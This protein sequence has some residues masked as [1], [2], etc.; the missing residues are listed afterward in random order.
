MIWR[1]F[2]LLIGAYQRSRLRYRRRCLFR[3][4]CSEYV[5]RRLHERGCLAALG[6]ALE[7]A[8]QCRPG[9]T[10]HGDPYTGALAVGLPDGSSIGEAEMAE[11]LVRAMRPAA[12]GAETPGH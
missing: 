9:F 11:F 2:D 4:S 5:R 8:R 10:V 7:R 12:P 6:A 3:E 1:L